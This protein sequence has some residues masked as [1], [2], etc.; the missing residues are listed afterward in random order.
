MTA[1]DLDR[2]SDKLL[3]LCISTDFAFIVLHALHTYSG[4]FNDPQ[5]SITRERGFGETFQYLKEGWIALMLLVLA[6][7]ASD[8][9]YAGWSLLFGYLL[10][11]DVFQLHERLGK[12]VSDRSGFLPMFQLRAQDFG[13]LA[14]TAFFASILFVVI[15]VAHHRSDHEARAFSRSMLVLLVALAVFGVVF[16]MV[17]VMFKNPTWDF[18]VGIIDDGGEMV[19]MSVI[20][21][22]VFQTWHATRRGIT[23]HR[24]VAIERR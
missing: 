16:D 12:T 9:L 23:E 19:V 3:L 7:R 4:Y 10:I 15:G 8:V 17:Q 20:V 11:D 1:V 5:F 22:F 21:R 14:V 18:A 2:A 6:V 13:E 24:A